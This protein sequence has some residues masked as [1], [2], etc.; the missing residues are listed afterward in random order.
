MTEDI[1]FETYLNISQKKFEIYLFDK[2]KLNNLY[3]NELKF[4]NN[5]EN[6]D[7]NALNKFLEDNIFKI[8]KLIGKFVENIFLVI[9]DYRIFPD[10]FLRQLLFQS[11]YLA[12]LISH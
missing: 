2:K 8:E 7:L 4:E 1:D 9:E 12:P 11:K 5:T 3:R 6:I 10:Y